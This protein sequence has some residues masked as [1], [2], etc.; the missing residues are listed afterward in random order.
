[1]AEYRLGGYRRSNPDLGILV[2]P[3]VL[4][5]IVVVYVESVFASFR[6]LGSRYLHVGHQW[7]P[8]EDSPSQK[9]TARRWTSS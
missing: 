1:M 7:D 5:H 9:S 6:S 3:Y 4:I 8:V 2:L